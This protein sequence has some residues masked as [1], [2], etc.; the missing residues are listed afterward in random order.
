[1]VD[2]EKEYTDEHIP[3]G[4]KAC[5]FL[6]KSTDPFLAVKS[7][8]DEL[9]AA[10]FVRLSKLEPFGGRLVPGKFFLLL[11]MF[12]CSVKLVVYIFNIS[13]CLYYRWEL[14]LYDKSFYHC[15]I[16]RRSEISTG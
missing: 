5:N 12:M 1:M 7:C 13:Y 2:I 9:D 15:G 6:T 16:Y 4:I 3:F 14:L 10:G 11:M 8:S